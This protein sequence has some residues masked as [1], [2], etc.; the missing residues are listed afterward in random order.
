MMATPLVDRT[1][2]K[3]LPSLFQIFRRIHPNTGVGRVSYFDA[4]AMLQHAQLFE[5]L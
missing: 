5:L 4:V 1:L 2:T 3:Q